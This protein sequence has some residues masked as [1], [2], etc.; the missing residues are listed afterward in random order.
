MQRATIDGLGIAYRTVGAGPAVL[1]VH[2]WPTSS[3][4]WR[5]VAPVIARRCR[6]ITVD[7][8]GFG[9]SDKPLDVRYDFAF[10]GGVIDGLLD[11]L[12]IDRVALGGHDM[13]GPIVVHWALRRPE[14]V[15]G[16]A[17]LNT[18]LYPE[19]HAAVRE[20]VTALRTPAS[21]DALTSADG[22]G[23]LLRAGL[24][25]PARA[26]DDVLAALVEPFPDDASRHALALAGVQLG[27]R[28]F[29]EIARDLRS[30]RV[31]VRVVYGERD[32]VLPDIA[33]TVARLRGDLP[34]AVVTALPHCGHFLQEDAPA[35]VGRLLA[36][37][38]STVDDRP[39]PRG[40]V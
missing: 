25:E 17:L 37:F 33:A 7:L 20:F 6:V 40:G 34:H 38:F 2:G 28:G 9:A 32:R 15:T 31:P 8:P 29:V 35:E 14:R 3:Y 18:L 16:I 21:R 30:L 4:L 39:G 23:E 27:A 12:G 22:L 10:F 11:R 1:L 13:G 36:D 19:F 26:T 5:N 24:A